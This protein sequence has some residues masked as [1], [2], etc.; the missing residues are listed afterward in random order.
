[1]AQLN[2]D[3]TVRA[4]GVFVRQAREK[5]ELK[6]S[7]VATAVGITQSYYSNIE[8]GKREISVT[9]ALNICDA[10][11]LDFNSFIQFITMKK[12]KVIRPELKMETENSPPR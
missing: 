6:Q 2:S 8:A 7:E 3:M 9:L 12:P 1:M 10:L 4:F 11:G 5:Q